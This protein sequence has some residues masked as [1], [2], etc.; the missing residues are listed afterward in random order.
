M[1]TSKV[2][3]LVALIFLAGFAGGIVTT[4]IVVR[5]VLQ[6]VIAHPELIRIR[7]ERELDR[8]LDLD[9]GQ[10][11]KVGR[12]LAGT[13]EQ[14]KALRGEFQPR[15]AAIVQDTRSQISVLLTPEQQRKF[16]RYQAEHSYL[17]PGR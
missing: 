15:F 7:I 16:E 3:L 1:K 14:L 5:R 17:L 4:R 13:H 12:I 6:R 10:R 9:A 8:K 2:W 11:A